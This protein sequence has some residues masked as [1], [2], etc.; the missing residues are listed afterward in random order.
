MVWYEPTARGNAYPSSIQRL[1]ARAVVRSVPKCHV[2][3]CQ[4]Y[5]PVLGPLKTRCRVML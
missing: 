4:N 2:G 3:G 1:G 5:G